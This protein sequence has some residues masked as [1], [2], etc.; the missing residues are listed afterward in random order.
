M[1]GI[2]GILGPVDCKDQNASV[3]LQDTDTKNGT[4]EQSWVSLSRPS[5]SPIVRN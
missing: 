1:Q 4:L 5:R 2:L 3:D